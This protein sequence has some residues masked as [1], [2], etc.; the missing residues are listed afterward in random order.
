MYHLF[1]FQLRHSNQTCE[2]Y[3]SHPSEFEYDPTRS[4]VPLD[5]LAKRS[6]I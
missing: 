4:P 6:Q 5:F 1:Q 2:C 3:C